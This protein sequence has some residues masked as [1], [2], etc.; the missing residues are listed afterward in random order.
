MQGPALAQVAPEA[1]RSSKKGTKPT[2]R[3]PAPPELA[4]FALIDGPRIAAAA[5]MSLSAW[6]DGVRRTALGQLRPGETPY[7]QPV[8]REPRCTRYRVADA[9]AWLQRRAD[10]GTAPEV[11]NAVV[12]NARRA[13][14]AAR[15][16]RAAAQVGA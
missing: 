11:A 9:R 5:C 2:I 13:S 15:S 7:P 16:K 4:E 12:Q 10:E 6:H 1:D 14:Q 3:H 8:I